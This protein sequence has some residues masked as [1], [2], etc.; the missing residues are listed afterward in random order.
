MKGLLA[1]SAA[2]ASDLGT[3]RGAAYSVRLESEL[4]QS[5]PALMQECAGVNAEGKHP[6]FSLYVQV[7]AAG[8]LTAVTAMPPTPTARC[9]RDELRTAHAP[10]P[11]FAPFHAKVSV[12]A[13][14]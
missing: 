5:H 14:G 4:F 9:I 1:W 3:A 8:A 6:P 13:E 7:D 10:S 11:P 12:P 2:I